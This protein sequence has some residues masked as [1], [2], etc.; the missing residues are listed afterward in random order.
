MEQRT[1]YKTR[2]HGNTFGGNAVRQLSTDEIAQ[3]DIRQPRAPATFVAPSP[4][5]SR[6]AAEQWI[7]QSALEKGIAC[8][9]HLS[10]GTR[11]AFACDSKILLRDELTRYFKRLDRTIYGKAN[12]NHNIRLPRFITLENAPNVGFH[13]HGILA[14]PDNKSFA[15]FDSILDRLWQDQ[16]DEYEQRR[17]RFTDQR[18][19][20]SE[21]VSAKYS[22]YITK[23]SFGN[24][25][26]DFNGDWCEKNTVSFAGHY[27]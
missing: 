8:C 2:S 7:G 3:T 27:K 1:P 10:S 5:P 19:F 25:L 20:W 18:L 14:L 6:Q 23:S 21:P 16:A 12:K 22:Q 24:I 9:W 17:N 4:N 11:A 26:N 13:A 15:D